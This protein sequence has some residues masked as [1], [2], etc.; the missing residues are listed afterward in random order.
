[1]ND[2]AKNIILWVVIAVILM[3]VFQNFGPQK[4]ALKSL[5]YTEFLSEVK[6]GNIKSVVIEGQTI[7]ATTRK[8]EK[9]STYSPE[10]PKLIDDL[11][12]S[13]VTVEARPP[14]QEFED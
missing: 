12:G 8:D 6:Q 13:G 7:Q 9:V 4:Q 2:I 5:T 10:D 11:L 3:T 14:E 1:M